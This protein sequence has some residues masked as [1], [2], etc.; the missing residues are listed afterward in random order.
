MKDSQGYTEK[1]YLETKQKP[2]VACHPSA[3]AAEAGRLLGLTAQL[4]YPM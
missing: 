4:V 2:D 3:G 1:P